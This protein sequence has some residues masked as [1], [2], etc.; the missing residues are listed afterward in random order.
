MKIMNP[1]DIEFVHET[2]VFDISIVT[3]AEVL[4]DVLAKFRNMQKIS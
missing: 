2:T 1:K 3:R 4:P